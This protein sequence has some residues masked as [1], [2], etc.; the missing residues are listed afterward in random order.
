[1]T[2]LDTLASVAGRSLVRD[3][4][5]ELRFERQLGSIAAFSALWRICTTE[6]EL[7]TLTRREVVVLHPLGLWSGTALWMQEIVHRFAYSAINAFV[8]FGAA[9]LLVAVGLNRTGVIE[10]PGV[11]VAGIVLEAL[12]LVL[13]FVVLFFAPADEGEHDVNAPNAYAE[14]MIREMGEIS[15]DYAAMA[16]Q[17]ETIS[18]TLSDVTDR[19]DVMVA[20]MKDSVQA[21]VHAVAPNPELMEAMR[22][23]AAA[24]ER[25]T[26]HIEELAER[27]AHIEHH[28]T[29][30][31]VR[32]ELERLLARTVSERDGGA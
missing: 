4:F 32:Q 17:L 15:R 3:I 31:L 16:V 10:S 21:A 26:E 13:L 1:M 14:E 25:F 5:R 6:R 2:Q 30:R 7:A 27:L 28:Q 23:T 22:S 12:L 18:A 19:Q 20:S 24:L 29:E 11:I 9:L 8:Y